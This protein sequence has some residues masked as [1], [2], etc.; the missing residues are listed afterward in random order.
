M[1]AGVL[2]YMSLKRSIAFSFNSLTMAMYGFI[3]ANEE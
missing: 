3:A 1:V 2:R